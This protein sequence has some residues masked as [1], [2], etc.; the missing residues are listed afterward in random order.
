MKF[1]DLY[2]SKLADKEDIHKF[3]EEWHTT[4]FGTDYKLHDFLGLTKEQ[5]AKW[6][7]TDEIEVI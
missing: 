4:D 7:E 3:I 5:Y 2:I 1:Y 6:V